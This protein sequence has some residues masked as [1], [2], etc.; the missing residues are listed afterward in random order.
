LRGIGV[1]QPDEDLLGHIR[2]GV[3]SQAAQE[4][5]HQRRP[6]AAGEADQ[7]SSV[8]GRIKTDS[9]VSTTEVLFYGKTHHAPESRTCANGSDQHL[10][11]VDA[12]RIELRDPP[13]PSAEMR[14]IQ[15]R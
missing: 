14:C 6:E 13:S 15:P 7:L 10:G 9:R 2:L 1:R 11:Y 4:K 3:I 5:G 8:S 12:K